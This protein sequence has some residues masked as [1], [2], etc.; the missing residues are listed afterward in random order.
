MTQRQ[1][2]S[3]GAKRMR[4]QGYVRCDVWLPPMWAAWLKAGAANYKIPVAT[5]CRL[6]ALASVTD[7]GERHDIYQ[8]LT[9]KEQAVFEAIGWDIPTMPGLNY[10][11][12]R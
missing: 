6:L 12:R 7:E 8:S 3:T 11:D 4:E 9:G 1:K 10:L 5:L 2:K